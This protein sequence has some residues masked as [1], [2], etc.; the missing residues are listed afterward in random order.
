[1]GDAAAAA[2]AGVEVESA[3]SFLPLIPLELFLAFFFF[4]SY[5]RLAI[6]L[7]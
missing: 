2:F 5:I 7:D 1:M 4:L 6:F 3:L